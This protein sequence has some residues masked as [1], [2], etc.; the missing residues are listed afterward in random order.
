MTIDPAAGPCDLSTRSTDQPQDA[1]EQVSRDG[2]LGQL[3]GDI[4]T[5]AVDGFLRRIA[6]FRLIAADGDSLVTG[7]GGAT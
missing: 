7:G 2:H 3:E 5:I 4:T 1:P 6:N